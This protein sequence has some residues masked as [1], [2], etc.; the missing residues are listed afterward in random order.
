MTISSYGIVIIDTDS[1][2][3]IGNGTYNLWCMDKWGSTQDGSI[4]LT[5]NPVDCTGA[6]SITSTIPDQDYEVP[7]SGASSITHAI[8][9][10]YSSS[11]KSL[12]PMSYVILNSS[13]GS[14]YSGF[15]SIDSSNNLVL[16]QTQLGTA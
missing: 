11:S 16:D 10:S 1:V 9:G 8:E 6:L 5:V 12:C 15:L 4:Y 7:S 3:A 13:D 14:L 2:T